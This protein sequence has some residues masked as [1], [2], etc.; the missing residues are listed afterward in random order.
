LGKSRL[1]PSVTRRIKEFYGR[2]PT[3]SKSY[4]SDDLVAPKQGFLLS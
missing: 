2:G 1:C 3:R 4:Y